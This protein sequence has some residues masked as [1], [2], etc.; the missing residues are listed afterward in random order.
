MEKNIEN[1]I[2]KES[3]TGIVKKTVDVGKKVALRTKENMTFAINKAKSAS[4]MKKLKKLNPIFPQQY[5]SAEF[6]LPNIIM[7]VDDA[8]RRGNKLCEGA[9]GW[10]SNETGVEIFC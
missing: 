1:K 5:E 6:N 3:I 7:I 10:L 8:I 9:V 2:T 4:L